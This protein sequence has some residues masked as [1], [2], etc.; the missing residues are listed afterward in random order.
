MPSIN[1]VS[2]NFISFSVSPGIVLVT[3]EQTAKPIGKSINVVDVFIT[4]I[5]ISAAMVIKPPINLGPLEPAAI[6]ICKAILL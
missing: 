5:L 2:K 4:N 1:E 6:I 3:T